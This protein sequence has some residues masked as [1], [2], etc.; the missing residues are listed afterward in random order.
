MEN[1]NKYSSE[2]K[3]PKNRQFLQYGELWEI[4]SGIKGEK[5]NREENESFL[6]IFANISQGILLKFMNENLP[7]MFADA[8][9]SKFNKG[10]C[11]QL[12]K[13]YTVIWLPL[14]LPNQI[15]K[16]SYNMYYVLGATVAEWSSIQCI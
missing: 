11:W 1:I 3:C 10:Y 4:S 14:V 6:E 9:W 15:W 13:K 2:K 16:L 5:W 8:E 12:W 7:W